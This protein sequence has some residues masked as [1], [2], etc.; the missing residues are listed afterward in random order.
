MKKVFLILA[1][2][3]S[4][5][6]ASGQTQ[7]S[8]FL[9]SGVDDAETLL[10]AYFEPYA[11]GFGTSLNAGWYN[12]AKVHN[13]LGFDLT[14]TISASI[15]PDVDKTFDINALALQKFE[16]ADPTDHFAPTIAGENSLGPQLVYNELNPITSTP[17]E[18]ASFESP[19]GTGFGY[20]PVPMLKAAVGLPLGTEIMGRYAP[21]MTFLDDYEFSLWG[22]GVKHD[23][24]Q[25]LPFLK[26]LPV[27]HI[28]AMGA[29]TDFRTTAVQNLQPFG[30]PL[31]LTTI[32][33]DNQELGFSAK[34]LTGSLLISANLPVI[35]FYGGIGFSNT[36]TSLELTGNYPLSTI[37][38]DPLSQHFG[39]V[40]LRDQDVLTDPI[41]IEIESNDGMR[42]SAGIRIKLALLTIH[43]DY[44]YGEYHVASVGIGLSFR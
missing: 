11:E 35:C 13:T 31:I 4:F 16:L 23:L 18:I 2:V 25:Y 32:P 15:I 22:I 34:G 24:K 42:Y 29:Y 27:F 43:A 19:K 14:L 20:L 7:V 8:N 5:L 9:Q 40:V 12:S 44:T 36:V 38:T 30:N 37:E 10:S 41:D 17:V 39:Q 6:S 26:R 1:I 33:F 28:S 21:S 3:I